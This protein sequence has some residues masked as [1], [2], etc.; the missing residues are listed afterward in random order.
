MAALQFIDCPGYSALVLRRSFA[1][2]ALPGALLDRAHSWLGKTGAQWKEQAKQWVFPLAYGS[3]P[4]TLNFGYLQHERDKYRYQSSEFDSINFDELTQFTKTQY[5]FMFSRLRRSAGS[6][7]PLR[8]RGASNPG[9]EGH[10]FVKVRFVKP[11]DPMRPFIPAN[12]RDNPF[13]DQASYLTSLSQLDEIT[14]KQLEE[15]V[16]DE[17]TPEGSYYGKW[18]ELANGQGRI[19]FVPY[20]PG[21]P[22][23]TW[24]D[25]GIAAGRD[26]MTIWFTQTFGREIRVIDCFGSSGEGFPY[27][28]KI[29]REKPYIYGAHHAPHDIQVKELG[30]GKSRLDQARSL[31]LVFEMVPNIGLDEGINAVRAILGRCRFDKGNCSATGLRALFNYKKEWDDRGQCWKNHPVKDWTNDWA[32]SFRM[33]AVGFRDKLESQIMSGHNH[34]SDD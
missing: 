7:I 14:R 26:S 17:P 20:E 11:G 30:T 15:G 5:T 19:G 6:P 2:L 3:T 18:L 24:W 34:H 4:P 8:M 32:D 22:V 1:D 25:L 29:L 13:I 28:V 33:L 16:W 21:L 9:N 23:E 10:E 27:Y 12:L 31:G